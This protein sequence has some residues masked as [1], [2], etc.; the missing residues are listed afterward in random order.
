MNRELINYTPILNKIKTNLPL[1][2]VICTESGR[3]LCFT[4]YIKTAV[5]VSAS[6]NTKLWANL[7]LTHK[8]PTTL[9][10]N[11]P[12]YYIFNIPSQTFKRKDLTEEECYKYIIISER[13]AAIDELHRF[14]DQEYIEDDDTKDLIQQRKE[15]NEMMRN[16]YIT[17]LNK[18]HT[19]EQINKNY[20][21][22]RREVCVYGNF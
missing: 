8:I 10:L 12:Q 5:V 7:H 4:N 15:E 3:I 11:L 22:L 21:E 1:H 2:S 19:L 16:R 13:A 9:N 17:L 20:D 6:R 14:L 18:S